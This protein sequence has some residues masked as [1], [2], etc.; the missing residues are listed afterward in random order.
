[1]RNGKTI[2][3]M[4]FLGGIILLMLYGFIQGF[5]EFM[6]AMDLITGVLLG[7]TLIGL[8]TL[9]ISIIL[10]QRKD[11]KETMKKIKKEDLKP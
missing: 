4:L 7:L 9:I 3:L 5:E 11:T 10:E 1:M 8:L 6:N 2:G